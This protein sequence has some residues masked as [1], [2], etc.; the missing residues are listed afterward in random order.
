MWFG[1]SSAV[2]AFSLSP[3][4][5]Q[6][7]TVYTRLHQQRNELPLSLF[8]THLTNALPPQERAFDV[9][10]QRLGRRSSKAGGQASRAGL[11]RV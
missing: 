10:R 4:I 7:H 1:I 5:L 2:T 6:R 3:V 8:C 11:L 9:N